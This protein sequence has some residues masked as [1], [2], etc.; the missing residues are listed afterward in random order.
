MCSFWLVDVYKR[1]QQF[2][3]KPDVFGF[4]IFFYNLREFESIVEEA[5]HNFCIQAVRLS[6]PDGGHLQREQRLL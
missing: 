6:F 4:D 2:L 3:V 1:Q 5:G